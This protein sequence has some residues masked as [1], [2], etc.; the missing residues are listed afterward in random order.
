MMHWLLVL[1]LLSSSVAHAGELY[2]DA[3][4]GATLFQRTIED[5]T[6]IQDALPHRTDFTSLAWRVG[7]G[8]RFTERWSVQ[9]N[10]LRMGTVT[11]TAR[12]V[13]D[14]DYD[15]IA[16]ACLANCSTAFPFTTIDTMHGG[17]LSL[18][19]TWLL[20]PV[21]PFLRGGGALLWHHLRAHWLGTAGEMHGWIP[22][23]LVGGGLCYGWACVEST[24]YH[25]IGG[26]NCL[27]PCGLPIAK[28]AVV[29]LVSL[30]IPVW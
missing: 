9:A 2:F 24:Y 17:E 3:A 6:W 29:S 22:M 8:Y 5:G 1:C 15:S 13:N 28:E 27:T 4:V 7:L 10:A 14:R 20:G 16:H 25:G 21:A 26:M 18:T 30:K 19:R 23:G 12:V 11:S